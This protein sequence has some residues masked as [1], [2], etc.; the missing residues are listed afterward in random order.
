MTWKIRGKT[1]ETG[2][3]TL[4]MGILNVTP[5]S[6]SDGGKFI[7]ENAAV[8]RGKRMLADGADIIDVGG[9]SSRPGS[10]P[11]PEEA[12]LRRVIP[13]IERLSSETDAVISVDTTKARVAD[14]AV[15]A[16]ASII[17]DISAMRFDPAM[18]G[19]AAKTGAGLVLMHML[20]TPKE[21]QVNPSY[22]DV[23][24]EIREFLDARGKAARDAGVAWEA[25][26]YDPGIGFGKTVE[27]NLLLLK[28]L[29]EFKPLMRPM[30]VGPSRKSFIGAVLDLPVE[31]RL[32]GTAAAVALAVAN[33]ADLVRVHDVKEMARVAKVADA[34]VR[35]AEPGQG[36]PSVARKAPRGL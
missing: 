3:R 11:V 20:G 7:D 36:P 27:H 18:A 1:I 2:A 15:R 19:V 31:E 21:M 34:V 6:F 8:Q 22:K 12:E 33:G 35:R 10:D 32:E 23:V 24:R 29:S 9:E 5:D 30:L 17:N 13:V 25:I 4:I 14:E 28:R 26:V 16:G